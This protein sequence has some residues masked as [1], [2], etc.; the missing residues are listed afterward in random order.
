MIFPKSRLVESHQW[1]Y[2]FSKEKEEQVDM[3]RF[4]CSVG[5]VLFYFE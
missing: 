3:L 5:F 2:K 1:N 4:S